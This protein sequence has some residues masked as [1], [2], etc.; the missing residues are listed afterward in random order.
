M[1]RNIIIL[2]LLLVVP[3]GI[4]LAGYPEDYFGPPAPNGCIKVEA[5]V[6]SG[7]FHDRNPWSMPSPEETVFW[8]GEL[9]V[10][11]GV[12]VLEFTQLGSRRCYENPWGL[13]ECYAGWLIEIS[14][15][16]R[17]LMAWDPDFD[18]DWGFYLAKVHFRDWEWSYES[19][20]ASTGNDMVFVTGV[21]E[22]IT[23]FWWVESDNWTRWKFLVS[24]R[25]AIGFPMRRIG[26]RYGL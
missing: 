21:F 16:D 6:P 22:F 20:T 15:P 11:N 18:I 4:V 9:C 12:A 7:W 5:Y 19:L 10:E 8:F 13:E 2:C 17:H 26:G 23:P 24:P 1:R 14:K 3:A 25:S